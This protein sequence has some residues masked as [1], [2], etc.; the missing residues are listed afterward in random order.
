V[1]ER[2][3]RWRLFGEPFARAGRFAYLECV[4]AHAQTAYLGRVGKIV[5][6]IGGSPRRALGARTQLPA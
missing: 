3:K 6:G 1:I 2:L 4:F 5:G